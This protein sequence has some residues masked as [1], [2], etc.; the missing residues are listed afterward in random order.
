MYYH[1]EIQ[2][3]R[4]QVLFTSPEMCLCRPKFSHDEAHCI[5][6]W[7]ET[8]SDHTVTYDMRNAQGVSLSGSFR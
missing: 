2:S 8:F 6:E 3:R 4:Y 1:Q 7:G 5:S